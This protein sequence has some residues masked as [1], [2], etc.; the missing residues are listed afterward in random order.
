MAHSGLP[1]LTVPGSDEGKNHREAVYFLLAFVPVN[2]L[3][4]LAKTSLVDANCLPAR[5]S[6]VPEDFEGRS[7]LRKQ[8][9]FFYKNLTKDSCN[10][11]GRISSI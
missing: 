10:F 1:T 11:S 4:G 8:R 3:L 7:Y 2:P 5:R 9:S 6:P